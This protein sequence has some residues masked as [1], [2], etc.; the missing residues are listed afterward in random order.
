[1]SKSISEITRIFKETCVRDLPDLIREYEADERSGVKQIIE[2][3]RKRIDD[4]I[5]ERERLKSLFYFEEKYRSECPVICGIDEAGRGPLA[6]PVVA[7]AVILPADVLDT[8]EDPDGMFIEGLNDSKQVSKKRRAELFQEITEK[9]VAHGVGVV[10]PAR[11]DEVNIR[12]AAM[13]A[14]KLAFEDLGVV[15]DMLLIDAMNLPD[16]SIRQV[17]IIKGDARSL[18]IAAASIVAKE[19]RDRMME[20]YAELYPEYHFEKHMGYGTKLHMD[21]LKEHGMCP[22]HRRTFVHL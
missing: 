2:K 17:N 9:A 16:V 21:M 7:G 6:G 12:V 8:W 1:M 18:S 15:P 13:E 4:R 5:A 10:P 19:T 20:N 11:I 14:M 3:A 22:I